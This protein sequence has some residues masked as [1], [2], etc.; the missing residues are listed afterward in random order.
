MATCPGRSLLVTR[1]PIHCISSQPHLVGSSLDLANALYEG[2]W[3]WGER[4]KCAVVCLRTSETGMG[5]GKVA[6]SDVACPSWDRDTNHFQNF[7]QSLS[8]GTQSLMQ[9]SMH[10][11]PAYEGNAS[12]RNLR[13]TCTWQGMQVRDWTQPSWNTKFVLL[14]EG[15]KARI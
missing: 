14:Y 9:A 11:K 8:A 3:A 12:R 5:R 7:G 15:T 2:E 4:V 6:G 13:K 1:F 10:P